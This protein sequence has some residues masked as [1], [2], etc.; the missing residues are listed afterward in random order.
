MGRLQG[1]TVD[2]DGASTRMDFEFIEIVDEKSSYP[3]LLGIYWAIDMNGII[4][5]K[6]RKMTF[7]KKSR[8]I[9]VLLDPTEGPRYTE[10]V[11]DDEQDEALD[12][13]YQIAAQRPINGK[14]MKGRK[15]S[16][17][18]TKPYTDESE[19]EDKQWQNRMNMATSL[20]CNMLTKSV[21]YLKAQDC[22]LPVYDRLKIVNEFLEKFESAIPEYQQ[23]DALKWALRVTPVRWWGTHEGTFI[24]W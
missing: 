24:D 10:P 16:E 9:V 21:Y 3:T 17:G 15:I 22:E 20:N 1:I 13:I 6:Q 11:R 19:E 2:L 14:A 7:E 18:Y 8:R 4:N 23:F 5:L 12:C